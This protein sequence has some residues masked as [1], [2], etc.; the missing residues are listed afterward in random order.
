MNKYTIKWNNITD[1]KNHTK[2]TR[3]D[4]TMNE[5]VIQF[6]INNSSVVN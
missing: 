1:K 2:K 3:T 4:D 6:W 5:S